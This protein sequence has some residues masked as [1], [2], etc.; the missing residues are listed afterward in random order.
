MSSLLAST[1]EERLE[2]IE[3]RL[4]EI[5]RALSRL[6]SSEPGPAELPAPESV[7]AEGS[8]SLAASILPRA[9]AVANVLTLVGRSCLVLGGAFLVRSLTDAGA[10]APAAGAAIG[11]AYAVAWILVADR[12]ARRGRAASAAF[13][14]IT[15]VVIAYP[16]IA[17]TATRFKVFTPPGAAGVLAV[18]TGLCLAVAWRGDLPALAW[19]AVLA[20]AS[21]AAVLSLV[22]GA[23]EVF[24]ASQL[25]IGLATAYLAYGRRQWPGLRWLGA[26]AADALVLW[27]ALRLVSE[28]FAE[29]APALSQFLLLAF[30][31]PFL[32]IGTFAVR[33][34]AR[35]ESATAFDVFESIA[36]LAVGLGGAALVV[37]NVQDAQPS[38]GASAVVIGAGCYGVAFVFVERRQ[39]HGR[40][41]FFYAT[42]ALLLTLSGTA[43]MAGGAALAI[44]W[45]ALALATSALAARYRR[46]TLAV[47]GAVYEVVTT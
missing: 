42:L 47:H 2:R 15:S 27:V 13:L 10:V 1:L 32:Y 29:R 44:L 21:T 16:L 35:R 38:L 8:A 9:G 17:E 30:A 40:N 6:Q 3:A 7:S 43:L 37:R 28:S 36:A 4:E 26:I 39:G 34:L 33:T 41:F 46:V 12:A 11:L 25:A 22:T 18:L 14:A 31:L 24:A 45:S 19:A 20:S 23:V 5:E